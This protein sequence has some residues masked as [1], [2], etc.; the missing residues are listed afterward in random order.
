MTR[1][2]IASEAEL[3]KNDHTTVPA[4]AKSRYGT[5][6]LGTLARWPKNTAKIAAARTGCRTAQPMP[7]LACLYFTMTRRITNDR[8]TSRNSQFSR[9]V[10]TESRP[11]PP[12][13]TSTGTCLDA[14]G[15]G[16]VTAMRCSLPDRGAF[17]I[18]RPVDPGYAD[19]PSV[20]SGNGERVARARVGA[21]LVPRLDLAVRVHVGRE[22]A[23]DRAPVDDV[24]VSGD[25][26]GEVRRPRRAPEV[27]PDVLEPRVVPAEV[28][29]AGLGAV[30]RTV[31]GEAHV[32]EPI[33]DPRTHHHDRLGVECLVRRLDRV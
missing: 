22:A 10:S 20:G 15:A 26:D 14:C 16:L 18:P 4:S 23:F 33:A 29:R 25:V 30:V 8:K 3:E 27:E 1:L 28:D 7:T 31:L 32:L 12:R 11:R 5:P 17:A 21:L 19:C 9:S 6:S 2:S 13:T 24:A